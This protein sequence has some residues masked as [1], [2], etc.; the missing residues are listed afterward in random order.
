MQNKSYLFA[1]LAGALLIS[2]SAHA[3]GFYIQEQ[4]ASAGGAAYSGAAT[5][6]KDASTIFFNPA[7]MTALDGPIG[8]LG[9]QLLAPNGSLD[10]TGSTF[11]GSATYAG[12]NNDGGNP[13]NLSPVPSGFAAIPISAIDGLWAGLGVTSPFGLAN[14]YDPDFFGRFDSV[15]SELRTVDVQPTLAYK[16]NDWLSL[17]AGINAQYV[18]AELTS[19]AYQGNNGTS[20]LKG[21]DWGVGYTLGAQ[22]HVLPTTTL[23]LNYRS[24]VH[25]DLQGHVLVENTTAPGSL[26]FVAADASLVTPDIASIGLSHELNSQWTLMG[27]ANWM[28]WNNFEAI[29]ARNAATGATISTV[30]QNYQAVWSYAIGAEYAYSP[31]WTFRGGL[32]YDNT[33]TTDEYRTTRTPDG[34]RTWFSGGAT[35]KMNDRLSLD[36]NLTYINVAEET[37]NLS[38]NGGL[39]AVRADTDGDVIIGGMALNYKF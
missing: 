25:Y 18:N 5:H 26:T 19:A 34:D 24:A 3:A 22:L 4:S 31:T 23:G 29:T 15:K 36:M 30:P 16:V 13:F 10:N 1:A 8:T 27:Q 35:Y 20:T 37:I 33:P 21:D 11:L 39:A 17:G 7:G 12:Y 38:R 2:T 14:K 9:V 6:T 28:G 32:Q